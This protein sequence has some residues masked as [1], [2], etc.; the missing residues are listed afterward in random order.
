MVPGNEVALRE[1]MANFI[2]NAIA[3]TPHGGRITLCVKEDESGT[4]FSVS[5]TGK[6]IPL[7]DQKKIWNPFHRGSGAEVSADGMGLGLSIVRE[8]AHLHHAAVGLQ[9]VEGEGST[10]S[11]SFATN[12]S[13]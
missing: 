8:I 13:S 12:R 5:D 4:T 3:H 9:S 2:K 6:G 1:L 7:S 11:V 10:F